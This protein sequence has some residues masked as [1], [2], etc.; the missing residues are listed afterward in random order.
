MARDC[1]LLVYRISMLN[2]FSNTI[3][4]Q[5]LWYWWIGFDIRKLNNERDN[6]SNDDSSKSTRSNFFVFYQKF[7][8]GWKKKNNWEWMHTKFQ[9]KKEN[10]FFKFINNWETLMKSISILLNHKIIIQFS[11][12]QTL[13]RISLLKLISH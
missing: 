2:F 12:K 7:V 11:R 3:V 8:Y 10:F 9:N 13:I 1:D 4:I 6:F 5:F